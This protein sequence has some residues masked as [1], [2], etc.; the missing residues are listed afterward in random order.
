MPTLVVNMGVHFPRTDPHI[1]FSSVKGQ[2]EPVY[3]GGRCLKVV[4]L[5]SL[6]LHL[7]ISET[8]GFKNAP[9]DNDL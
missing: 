1:V 4:P 8:L 6:S 5:L 3:T 2:E 9:R 7:T